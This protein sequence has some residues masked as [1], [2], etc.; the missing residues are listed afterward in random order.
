M[1]ANIFSNFYER[2]FYFFSK[3]LPRRLI[4]RILDFIGYYPR[5]Y[6]APPAIQIE[7]TNFCNAKCISCSAP[8]SSRN[9]GYMD[10]KFFKKIV[11]EAS[12]IGTKRIDLY[13]HGEPLLHSGLIDMIRLIKRLGIKIQIATNGMLLNKKKRKDCFAL[14]SKEKTS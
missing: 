4:S 8:R 9:K 14:V 2:R 1:L 10:F 6:K 12:Q 13:L 3:S 7:P 11:D 5:Y